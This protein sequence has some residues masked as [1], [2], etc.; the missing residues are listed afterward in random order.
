M[1]ALS[2]I[3]VMTLYVPF[4]R[5]GNTDPNKS[6]IAAADQGEAHSQ[7]E[8]VISSLLTVLLACCK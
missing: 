4:H 8:H 5:T 3:H 6:G 2:R 7:I 1:H